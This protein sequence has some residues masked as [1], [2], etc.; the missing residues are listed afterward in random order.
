MHFSEGGYE[1]ISKKLFKELNAHVYYLEYDTARAGGF[2]V[3]SLPPAPPVPAHPHFRPRAQPLA[4][5]PAHKS[6]VLGLITSKFPALEDKDELVKR[7]NE[8]A[9]YAAQ[10]AGQTREEALQRLCL[11]PQCA[12]LSHCAPRGGFEY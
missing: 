12:S 1:H 5:L 3:R 2:E 6:V 7:I 11:S 9:E 8:A 4:D 10:G